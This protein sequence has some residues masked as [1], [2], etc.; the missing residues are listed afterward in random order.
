LKGRGERRPV[1]F[2]V[3]FVCILL[4]L[5]S[6]PSSLELFRAGVGED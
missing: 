3:S 4:L 6:P 2:A 1:L 5:R